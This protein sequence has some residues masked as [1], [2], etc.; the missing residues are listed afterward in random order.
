MTPLATLYSR[1]RLLV[2]LSAALLLSLVALARPPSYPATL[3]RLLLTGGMALTVFGVLERWPRQLP[4]WLARW[5]LQV[6]GVAAAIPLGMAIAYT[7]T[8]VGSPVPWF[9]D[10]LRRTGYVVQ[11]LLGLLCAPWIAVAALLRQIKGEARHQALAFAL[12]RSQLEREALEARLRLMHAQVQPHFLFNT[13]A[14]V[15]EL[16]ATGSAQAGT[17]L[18]S[19][20]RY[21]RAAVPRLQSNHTT[22]G[23]EFDMV[24]AYLEVMQMRMPDRLRF[25]VDLPAELTPLCCP[26]M[27]VLPLV[28]NAVRHGI[29]P[30][31]PGGCIRVHA[32]R[33][34][35][36]LQITVS[37]DGVGLRP[38][39]PGLG[40][41]LAILRE[42]L[43]LSFGE[44]A[45]LSV[46]PQAP[47]GVRACVELPLRPAP[48]GS[49]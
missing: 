36:G 44:G 41:G 31:L 38:G 24:R 40:T 22:L 5:A 48:G 12:E 15:R 16:V 21:L 7:I 47:K 14:N 35:G 9:E 8:T 3:L 39:T 4:H 28:E 2:V 11:T 20:I 25:E 33:T 19:L 27:T 18:D 30:S 32:V 43:R 26:T 34:D 23:E 29:D 46:I 17:V 10:E 6:A 13:L 49:A 45:R 42:R 37:D 1:R